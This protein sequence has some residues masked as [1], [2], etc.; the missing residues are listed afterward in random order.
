MWQLIRR[1]IRVNRAENLGSVVAL[2]AAIAVLTAAA[3]WMAAGLTDSA[4]G[5]TGAQVTTLS[6]SFTGIAS[7]LAGMT[8]STTIATG[9][10]ER[11]RQFA[12][13]AA[14]GATRSRLRSMVL[15]E[16][17]LLSAL[18]VPVG[19]AAG[20]GLARATAPLLAT[21]GLAPSGYR[22]PFDP[23]AVLGAVTT[24]LAVAFLSAWAASRHT[25]RISAAEA[26]STSGT[27]AAPL[28]T[29]RRIAAA[30]TLFT[31]LAT[32]VAPVAVPGTIGVALAAMSTFLLITA[33]ALAGPVVAAAVAR[34]LSRRLLATAGPALA[35]INVRGFSR[36]LTAVLVPFALVAALG[37]VQLSTNAIADTAA[38]EQLATGLR[39]GLVAPEADAGT[40]TAL[41]AVPGVT[42]VSV[43]GAVN[44]QVRTD[45][46]DD[47]PFT[48]WESTSI[49]T[50]TG[51]R[52]D[53]VLD[54][55]VSSGSLRDLRGETTVA[56]SADTLLGSTDGVGSTVT[57]RI[58]GTTVDRTIVAVYRS[59]LGFG[60]YLI[61]AD[62]A[63]AGAALVTIRPDARDDVVR[64]AAARGITL[65][66]PAAHAGTAAGDEGAD[67]S[68]VLLFALLA[69]GL[70]AAVNTL[71][72][73]V[74]S[75]RDEFA[76]LARI[77]APRPVVIA[78]V[79]TET[80]LAVFLAVVLGTLAALPAA[81][82]AGFALLTEW[83]DLPWQFL[84]ALPVALLVCALLPAALTV[85]VLTGRIRYG[86]VSR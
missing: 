26:V 55:D 32:A 56:V 62:K 12:L 14:V 71:V 8:V 78:T 29:G 45:Q 79:L 33:L 5:D 82:G 21:T 60:D 70:L 52:P 47:L 25:V 67:L 85:S 17:L 77:G 61:V 15:T 54:P 11:H 10:R 42:D 27:E 84:G 41:R 57:T 43:L 68:N 64:T 2:A 31:G 9:L 44:G 7:L 74:R 69:F 86:Y 30:L 58:D 38:R 80:A 24:L 35:L 63:E 50:L 23:L 36:R 49:T 65:L 22:V 75:R 40:A 39:P 1:S 13:L 28:G 48:L 19:S 73:L 16:T 66:T 83:P 3:L 81:A 20:Y 4:L 59:S 18:A 53:R 6:S 34:A 46:D 72:S 37:T 76:L 51:S